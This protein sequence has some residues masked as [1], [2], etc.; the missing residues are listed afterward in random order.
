M[1]TSIESTMKTIK[2]EWDTLYDELLH[3]DEKTAALAKRR[4]EIA[5]KLQILSDTHLMLGGKRPL[6]TPEQ[7]VLSRES[8]SLGD[9]IEAM[10][11]ERGAMEKDEL[12]SELERIGRITS[13]NAR[14]IFFN[15]VM[16]DS[17]KRFRITQEGKVDLRRE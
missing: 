16:R 11:K 8:S 6:L 2:Q 17:K 1:T 13:K 3:I 9:I 5:Q 7:K 14:V 4:R 12:Q 10:L 15:A